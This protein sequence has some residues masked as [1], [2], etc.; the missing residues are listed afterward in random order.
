MSDIEDDLEHMV[1]EGEEKAHRVDDEL[2]MTPMVDVT[3]LLLIFFMI[4]AAFALQKAL[5]VPPV[6]EDQA[7]ASQTIDDLEKDSIVIRIDE[8]NIFWVGSPMW[9]E[10]QKAPSVQE[11]RSKVREARGGEGGKMGKGPTKMLVQAHGGAMYEFAVAA[12]DAGADI[13]MPEVRFMIYE[14]GDL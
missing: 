11:M 3:F 2:D 6:D 5:E 10:E 1:E 7:A 12:L 8:D 4:T 9:G 14:D 13:Q